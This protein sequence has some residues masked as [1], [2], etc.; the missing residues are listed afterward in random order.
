MSSL[1]IVH[2][3]VGIK[4]KCCIPCFPFS[5]GRIKQPS[6]E[7]IVLTTTHISVIRFLH[8]QLPTLTHWGWVMYICITKLG[9]HCF[10]LWLSTWS[11]PSHYLNQCWFIVNWTLGN[12]LQWN[13][14]QNID[15]LIQIMHLKMSSANCQSFCSS[16]DVS[17]IMHA[18]WRRTS[19][20]DAG[21][22]STTTTCQFGTRTP[23]QV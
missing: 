8:L 3:G 1:W 11:V 6:H 15:I 14:N 10:R 4:V 23:L 17:S 19:I 18:G 13:S 2:T 22:L 12:K 5:A 16:L 20:S 7:L 21:Q 9:H